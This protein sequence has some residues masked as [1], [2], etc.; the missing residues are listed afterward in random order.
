M[1]RE[2]SPSQNKRQKRNDEFDK[3]PRLDVFH[4]GAPEAQEEH[5]KMENHKDEGKE[6]TSSGTQRDADVN[7]CCFLK[8]DEANNEHPR[9][10]FFRTCLRIARNDP[11]LVE[12]T[13]WR[14][15]FLGYTQEWSDEDL[16][17][18]GHALTGNCHLHSL[19]I[20]N[21]RNFARWHQRGGVQALC[22]GLRNSQVSSIVACGMSHQLKLGLHD[23]CQRPTTVQGLTLL[24]IKDESFPRNYFQ[25]DDDS[26]GSDDIVEDFY[27]KDYQ[28]EKDPSKH[29]YKTC[30][31]IAR[32]DPTLVKANDWLMDWCQ[33]PQE[34]YDEDL[35]LLGHA[36]TG[37][38]HLRTLQIESTDFHES[39][40]RKGGVPVLC[41]GIHQCP[42]L[43]KL[44]VL[45][46]SNELQQSLFLKVGML[47]NIQQLTVCK[48]NLFV[49][50]LTISHRFLTHLSLIKCSVKDIDMLTLSTRDFSIV[51]VCCSCH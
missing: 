15:C 20:E 45:G 47:P 26:L 42:N 51:L 35:Y 1:E 8:T 36:L 28:E 50:Y 11:T 10:H 40:H 27:F 24:E 31:R 46:M 37:N 2:D 48:T 12:V 9:K 29:F 18:L 5:I 43:K 39:V 14:R 33:D 17:L 3:E 32:N 19:A 34:W 38:N 7:S 22:H 49:D 6:R 41:Q 44:V 16:Y 23:E 4:E 13:E 25:E 30:L 21:T